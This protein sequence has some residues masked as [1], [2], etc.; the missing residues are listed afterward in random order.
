MITQAQSKLTVKARDLSF[1]LLN[2]GDI[3]K[4]AHQNTMINQL[5]TNPIDGSLNNLY[6]RVHREGQIHFYPLLGIHS[7]SEFSASQD[8]LI[9][10]GIAADINYVVTFRLSQNGIWF[11]DVMFEGQDVEIDVIYGQ[12]LGLASD[13]TVRSNEAYTAQYI[14]HSVFEDETK[15]YVI[16][17]RQNQPQD[18][19]F[20]YIQQ[21]ALT[22]TVGYSTDGFQFF[23]LS[24]KETNQPEVLT[25]E[26][27]ANNIYQYE[28]AYTALQSEKVL[29]DGKKQFV[30]YGLFKADHPSAVTRLEFGQEILSAWQDV[31]DVNDLVTNKIKKASLSPLF[32]QTL[33]SESL[34]KEDIDHFFPNRYQEE[35]DGE[36]LISFFTDTHEH[37][38]LKEKEMLV[39]RPHGHI[40][41]SGHNI[42]FTKEVMT[43]TSYMY[44]IFNSQLTVGN[45]SFNKMISNVRN[46]LNVMKTSGQRIYVEFGEQYHLLTIPSMFEI[47]FNYV[48]WFY[49]TKDDLLI[50]TNYTT[51]NSPEVNLTVRSNSNKAYNYIVT[52]QITMNNNEYE[53]PFN[54]A[55]D[56]DTLVFKADRHSDS[57]K[58]YSDLSYR[59]RVSGTEY[60]VEDECLF[61]SN[62][63]AKS[64]SLVVLKLRETSQWNMTIQ[65][66]LHGEK[67]PFVNRDISTEIER[68][69]AFY[70][71]VMNDF[72]LSQNDEVTNELEK[73][74][75]LVW[76]YTH[77]MLVH[78]SVPHGLEQYGGAA[79]GTR[80]VCQ[81]PSEYFIATQKHD[82]LRNIIKTVYSHQFEDH[83]NWPQWFMFDKYFKIQQD[84]SH[85]DIIVWPLKILSDY[86]YNTK[87]YSLL[88]EEVPYTI[89]GSFEFSDNKATVLD[90][91]KKEISYIKGH[92]LHDTHLSSYGDGDWDDTL[93]PANA[94]LKKYMVSCWTVALTYQAIKRFAHVLEAINEKEATEL[95]NLASGI[96]RDFNKYMLSSGVIPGFVYMKNKDEVQLMLHPTDT[97]TGINYRLLPMNRGIISEL[98]TL[99]QA[100]DH[101]QIIKEH[102]TFPDGVRLMNQPA[103]YQGGVSNHFKRAEQASNFGRE[104]GLQYVH[105]HIRFIEAMAKLG[106]PDDVWH[107][108]NIINPVNIQQAVP[109][110]DRRQSN[111]YF[112]SS[113]GK[114][115]TRYDAQENFG[116]LKD[117]SVQVKGGWRIYSSGPGIYINQLISNVLGIRQEEGHLVIDPVLPQKLDNLQFDFTFNDFPM[118]FKYHISGN[119]VS[120]VHVNGKDVSIEV[121]HNRYRQSGVRINQQDLNTFLRNDTNFV[122]IYMI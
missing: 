54:M 11:W 43:T 67:V 89:R 85:G 121:T 116:K 4:I 21:G 118:T 99:E 9:W 101:Y 119:K 18:G 12:D 110:A 88:T 33:K 75:I 5:L 83:G 36:T 113:D 62:I 91:V 1:T 70:R 53:V 105:A 44:G 58:I 103:N 19:A 27:L 37:V 98:F 61:A 108:L 8:K 95:H 32:G 48:R 79:W 60:T 47:G 112:S 102:L 81:G 41:M 109:N 45:T 46:P 34:T 97:E 69:R 22:K 63:E 14:D 59:I 117:G 13:G 82:A 104:I 15:G 76:W 30:F 74:N 6:L 42:D 66:L 94:Q 7:E 96:S 25:K 57:A 2:S 55:Q 115:N 80:D 68:Y 64:A 49:K 51:V 35:W 93:Q 111:S 114:F 107:G 29:L 87:D 122:E 31:Q 86:L 40:L 120:R 106:K 17:S 16:C 71:D 100:E 78:Y 72:H 77:N 39:E 38:V 65:G 24:Y 56:G 28:F 52:S 26:T 84:D 23:G 90:H 20:P 3:Y 50:I 92:F 10:K 73:L